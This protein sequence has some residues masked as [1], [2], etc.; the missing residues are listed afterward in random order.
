MSA[1]AA[2]FNFFAEFA[3][4][5]AAFTQSFGAF[6]LLV[7]V[8]LYI[9]VVLL[10]LP[11]TPFSIAAG[12]IYGWWGIPIAYLS[13]MTGAYLAFVFA[14][15]AG[16]HHVKRYVRKNEI[17]NGIDRCVKNGGW[18]LV[19]LI[20]LSGCL[21]F[22]VQNYAFGLSAVSLRG[23]IAASAIGL[24]PGAV[25]KAWIGKSSMDLLDNDK[26]VN[27]IQML[28]LGLAILLTLAMLVYVGQLAMRELRAEG[29]IRSPK[30]IAE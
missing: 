8:A 21:P 10:F 6:G 24:L 11:I 15:G 12:A 28:S 14:R 29:V 4:A 20:R 23:Y 18:R 7:F 1:V 25:I 9:A 16:R 26:L 17:A 22:A 13:A 19:L 2:F 30:E 27:T 3:E 5:L